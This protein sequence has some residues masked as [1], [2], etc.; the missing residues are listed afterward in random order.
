MA[1]PECPRQGKGER[2]SHFRNVEQDRVGS[3]PG[4]STEE[5]AVN[6]GDRTQAGQQR[7]GKE[8]RGQ[9]VAGWAPGSTAAGRLPVPATIRWNKSH[10]GS[11]RASVGQAG[12]LGA[13]ILPTD[14]KTSLN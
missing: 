10:G 4:Q 8:V 12:A 3:W 1:E 14:F 7:A 9:A 2:V 13:G 5:Q 11:C 6:A